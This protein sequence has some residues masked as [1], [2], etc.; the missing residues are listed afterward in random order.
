MNN[1]LLMGADCKT[2]VIILNTIHQ[3]MDIIIIIWSA[4]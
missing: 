4:L 2:L 3:N 1:F